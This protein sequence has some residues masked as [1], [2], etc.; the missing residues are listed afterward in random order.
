MDK[1]VDLKFVSAYWCNCVSAE[2][3]TRFGWAWEFAD[4]ATYE[5]N[6]RARTVLLVLA[7]AIPDDYAAASFAAGPLENYVNLIVREKDAGEADFVVSS[8]YLRNLLPLVRGSVDDLWSL[9]KTSRMTVE[10]SMPDLEKELWILEIRQLMGFWCRICSTSAMEQYDASYNQVLQKLLNKK[11]REGTVHDITASAP[12]EKLLEY[13]KD[14]IFV[15][16]P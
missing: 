6:D 10:F 7:K 3:E 4:E 1:E 15:L 14:N 16:E 13:V 8:V 11:T 2:Y 9:A 5:I 12:D